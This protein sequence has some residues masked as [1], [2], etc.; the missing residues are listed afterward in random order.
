MQ[1]AAGETPVSLALSSSS[2]AAAES[3]EEGESLTEL[4]LQYAS[5]YVS[6]S[7]PVSSRYCRATVFR[8]TI[9]L[10]GLRLLV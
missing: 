6:E 4:L 1:N 7:A 10:L 8:L 5:D 2:Y 9:F 3:S